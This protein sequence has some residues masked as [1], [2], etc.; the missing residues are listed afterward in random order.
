MTY[1]R[2]TEGERNQIYALM[3]AGK[4]NNEIARQIGRH[5]STVSREI[6]RN[7]GGR[8]YRPGQ[9]QEKADERAKRP[10]ARRFTEAVRLDAEERLRMGWT[11][12][13]ISGRARLE[14][15][16]R[17]CK[18]TIYGHVYADAKE[19]G[20]LWENLPRAKRGRKRRCPRK[21]GRGRIKDRRMIDERPPEVESRGVAGH[22]EGDLVNGA[23]GTGNLVT[24]VERKTRF[25]LVARVQ[26]KEASEVADAVCGLMS[27]FPAHIRRSMTFDNGKEFALHALIAGAAG[28]DVYF[29]HPYRSW[30]RA[31]NE[32]RNGL[33]RRL[34]PKKSSFAEIAGAEIARIGSYVNDRPH[35]CLGWRTPREAMA[36]AVSPEAS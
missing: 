25:L 23:A 5:K 22:W 31:T 17:V 21:D 13:M 7:A 33:V 32:N 27:P 15:R 34:H 10:G 14:G 1:K 29:A 36:A 28:L 11:P 3:Q 8:G 20:R 30:E 16:P 9:A 12:E 4:G 2:I 35:K 6:K 24:L 18:E 26:T 19:G